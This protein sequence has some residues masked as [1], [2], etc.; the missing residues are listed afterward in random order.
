MQ[1][2]VL[3]C[4]E[5]KYHGFK[6]FDPHTSHNGLNRSVSP[7]FSLINLFYKLIEGKYL[8]KA[9]DVKVSVIG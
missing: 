4:D 8:T 6:I 9:K 7:E 3:T 1:K 2:V 5:T